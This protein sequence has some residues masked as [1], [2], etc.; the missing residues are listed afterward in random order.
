FALTKKKK[1]PHAP[2]PPP[3]SDRIAI[4]TW[5]L[6]NYF[7]DTREDDCKLP[8]PMLALLDFPEM[9]IDRYRVHHFEFSSAHFPSTEPAYLREMKS[10]LRYTNSTVVS[11][12]V[13]IDVCGPDGE[14]SNPDPFVCSAALGAVEE[15]V[16]VAH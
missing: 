2:S 7:R 1:K 10:V 5:S 16:D 9:I 6:H 12:S 14:F 13:D 8:G 15:W 3:R 11:L 4:S